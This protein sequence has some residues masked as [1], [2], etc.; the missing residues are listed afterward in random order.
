VRVQVFGPHPEDGPEIAPT[1]HGR[2]LLHEC[3]LEPSAPFLISRRRDWCLGQA[4]PRLESLLR[5]HRPGPAAPLLVVSVISV[6]GLVLELA[7]EGK[8]CLPAYRPQSAVEKIA[9]S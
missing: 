6:G 5:Q 7:N 4:R 1:V 8:V 3:T 2:P 9:S